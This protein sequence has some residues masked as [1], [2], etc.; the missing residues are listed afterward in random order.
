MTEKIP[1]SNF[2]K[3]DLRIGKILEVEPHPNADKLLVLKVDLSEEKPRT[4][5]AG[6]KNFYSPEK[7]IG[8]KAIF[9]ANLEPVTLRGT[10]SNGMILAAGSKETNSCTLIKPEKDIPEGTKVS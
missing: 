6:I 1:Y 10:E 8:K 3:L 7:L 9:V 5:V 2:A 4:I